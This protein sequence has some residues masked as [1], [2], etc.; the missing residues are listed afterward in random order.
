MHRNFFI[1]YLLLN[2]FFFL[3][4]CSIQTYSKYNYYFIYI[5]SSIFY[6]TKIAKPKNLRKFTEKLIIYTLV[7]GCA[8]FESLLCTTR[9]AMYMHY[10]VYV[11]SL[12]CFF[13]YTNYYNTSVKINFNWS[14]V[15]A[16]VGKCAFVLMNNLL[17]VIGAKKKKMQI[18]LSDKINLTN[19]KIFIINYN[20]YIVCFLTFFL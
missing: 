9:L 20:V 14:D 3:F 13:M 8:L 5:F 7:H 16:Y 10:I 2:C 17:F 18:I 19:E 1:F 6:K 15:F 4:K 12:M 11:I